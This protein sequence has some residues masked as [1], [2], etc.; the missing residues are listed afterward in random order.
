LNWSEDQKDFKKN[1]A[2]LRQACGFTYTY[3]YKVPMMALVRGELNRELMLQ[4]TRENF[5]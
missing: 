1:K 4:L 3:E 5:I 2:L